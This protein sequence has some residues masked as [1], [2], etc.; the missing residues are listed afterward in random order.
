MA[1]KRVGCIQPGRWLALVGPVGLLA[2]ELTFKTLDYPNARETNPTAIDG[3]GIAG[4][5]VDGSYIWRGFYWDESGFKPVGKP[6]GWQIIVS[7]TSGGNVVGRYQYIVDPT[8]PD[9]VR[10]FFW[11]GSVSLDLIPPDSVRDV[12]AVG[13]SGNL[14]VGHYRDAAT[15]VHGF[16]WNGSS[17][18]RFD[19]LGSPGTW[20]RAI[21]GTHVAGDYVEVVGGAGISRGFFWDGSTF[22]PVNPP[23]S[24]GTWVGGLHGSDVVGSYRRD[25]QDSLVHGFLWNGSAFVTLDP[26]GSTQ[27]QAT[28][29]H[30]GRAVGF[31]SDGTTM[32]GFLWDGSAYTILEVPGAT[33]TRPSGI[34]ADRITGQYADAAG[35]LR[36]FVTVI[37]EPPVVIGVGST[38]VFAG[39]AGSV[40]LR[41]STTASVTNLSVVLEV[42]ETRLTNLKLQVS[43]A[44][45]IA[46]ELKPLSANHL[47]FT[48]SLDPA[49]AGPGERELAQVTFQTGSTGTSEIV[50][51]RLSQP[52]GK[53]AS[54]KE[55]RQA[56]ANSGRV[57]VVDGAPVLTVGKPPWMSVVLYGYPD[58]SYD[59]QSATTPVGPS[60]Q[61]VTNV[62]LSGPFLPIDGLGLESSAA[63]YRAR[64]R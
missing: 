25:S 43:A 38:H 54:G 63:F 23:G 6:D 10:A 18:T 49:L 61:T 35:K 53:L 57:V 55:V 19:A 16:L 2:G 36:G 56:Q 33:N 60:W 20:P 17:Y 9:P 1:N 37:P 8:V 22:T 26:P 46:A 64:Q 47:Q 51:L 48:L 39:S 32:R 27:T 59:L 45:V 24:S 7:G 30:E 29:V 11:N 62:T 44:E 12:Y 40:P 14:V 13:V 31:F 50:P 58:V 52:A 28:A 21:S 4:S 34:W 41:L 3:Q 15:Y 42:S 5:Y